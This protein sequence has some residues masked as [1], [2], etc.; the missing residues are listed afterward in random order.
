MK[1]LERPPIRCEPVRKRDLNIGGRYT[2][3][4]VRSL[5]HRPWDDAQLI[6]PLEVLDLAVE[7][8]DGRPAVLVR[9]GYGDPFVIRCDA[10][11]SHWATF[12]I[13]RSQMQ[14]RRTSARDH[15][16]AF[17]AYLS[18]HAHRLGVDTPPR[19]TLE[20]AADRIAM[21][22]AIDA[23]LLGAVLEDLERRALAHGE[24]LDGAG[25]QDID[26]PEQRRA[27]KPRFGDAFSTVPPSQWDHLTLADCERYITAHEAT[28][29]PGVRDWDVACVDQDHAG[30]RMLRSSQLTI[31]RWAL[32]QYVYARQLDAACARPAWRRLLRVI[33]AHA[34]WGK[35]RPE[36]VAWRN[37]LDGSQVDLDSE[38][39]QCLFL[40]WKRVHALEQAAAAA[41][42]DSA[43]GALL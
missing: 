43:L 33:G 35:D 5:E 19:A 22:S 20:A 41:T 38:T 6:D 2:T 26:R 7:P 4:A 24:P 12:D 3:E 42:G 30:R 28:R 23:R 32:R 18:E 10:L 25:E 29:V 9:E 8:V 34:R 16:P 17:N 14:A 1:H 27:T 39:V 11:T 40:E 36:Y 31:E 37:H 21:R 13:A 15:L